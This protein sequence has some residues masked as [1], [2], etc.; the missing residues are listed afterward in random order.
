MKLEIGIT[1]STTAIPKAPGHPN[2]TIKRILEPM[3]TMGKMREFKK[4][5]SRC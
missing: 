4:A 3:I 1:N 5:G 2:R